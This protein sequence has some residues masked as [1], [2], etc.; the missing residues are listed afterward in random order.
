MVKDYKELDF[1]N[2]FLF[3]QFKIDRS[4]CPMNFCQ[5]AKTVVGLS[6]LIVF[7]F[8]SNAQNVELPPGVERVASIE[9]IT[10]YR[11]PNGLRVLLFPDPTKQTITVNVAYLVG[12]RHENYG[13]TGMAH[14]LE[15]LMFK[16]SPR[17]AHQDAEGN[18]HGARLNA[19][20]WFDRTIYEETFPATEDNLSWALD[21]E[22]DRMLNAAVTRKDL[23]SEFSVVR[24]EFEKGENEPTS[25]L[26]DKIFAT[27]Y[28]WHNYGNTTIGA[29][30]DIE[31]VSIERLQ[32][33]YKTYY[34]PDN[35]VLVIAGNLNE[36]KTLKLVDQW[37]SPLARP[38]RTLPTLYTTEPVQDGERQVTI[39][40]IGDTQLLMAGYHLPAATS[41]DYGAIQI[42][43]QILGATPS[44]RL[45]KALVEGKKAS[46]VGLDTLNLKEP[47]FGLFIAEVRRE[48]PLEPARDTLLKIIENTTSNP[49]TAEEVE[50]ARNILLKNIELNFNDPESM[51]GELSEWAGRG[52]WRMFFLYRD[53]IKKTTI[54][55][56]NRVAKQYLKSSNRTLA[57][58]IPTDKP[59]RSEIA[60]TSERDV[61]TMLKD[62]KGGAPV[63][64]GETFLPSPENIEARV[65]RSNS[66]GLKVA[67]L[68]KENRGDT[69]F[70]NL[71]LRFG[72]EKSLFNRSTAAMFVERM[73]LRGTL[74]KSRQK[75][76]DELDRLRARVYLSGGSSEIRLSIETVRQNLPAVLT[77][78]A[79]I[80][81]EPSFPVN[82][83][84][85]ARQ[86]VLA[87]I[88]SSKSDP[89][90]IASNT[91]ERHFAKYPKGDPR[92]YSTFDEQIAAAKAVTL[93][94]LRQFHKDFYGASN[95]EL[96]IVGDFD[97]KEI[98]ALADQLFGSWKSP[99][100]FTRISE[101]F[102]EIPAVNQNIETPDKESANFEARI[103]LKLGDNDPDFPAVA[104]GTFVFGSGYTSRLVLRIREKEG[105][106][107]DLGAWSSA[108]ALD[109]T[110]SVGAYA[111]F[112]PQNAAKFENS[113]KEELA[114]LLKDGITAGELADAKAGLIE[115]FKVNRSQDSQ[116]AGKLSNYL[117]YNRTM[118]WDA[119]FEK[120][121][122]ALTVEQVN[123]AL[124]KYVTPDKITLIKVGD[125]AGAKAK[126]P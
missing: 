80:L 79:E 58:F 82:E 54:A 71:T 47:G 12:S 89:A 116:L 51:A 13:E 87:E 119:D 21:F 53:R 125:F 117:F 57:A 85:Q 105:L 98:T 107:Y 56:V 30:S 126:D 23:D 72:D 63:A 93:V 43:W 64:S 109:Q 19:N 100:K 52:D 42:L 3:F 31:N 104:V 95:G 114:R 74:K 1:K 97:E 112:A 120:K 121:I 70:A 33:F 37:F 55:D 75:I 36:T 78:A 84:E 5:L 83:F 49:P 39:R 115:R 73:L 8:V 91:I 6:L 94:Q 124:R 106:S 68:A 28:Q 122:A 118:M 50:R 17:H 67:L 81:R 18:Q 96:A 20:T 27:A 88:E 101:S 2:F 4:L 22:A 44:G 15:H 62:Y 45:H 25:V 48:M 61:A 110:G 92:Y 16:G 90:S 111:S 35:A 29:R 66:G 123:A 9:G 10:E 65:K 103:S 76:Q 26:Y 113:F 40:R 32:A 102:R 24:N 38:A 11:F 77:L 34:Q 108:D 46:S 69:V 14:L 86:E 60:A 59:D 99:R 7:S 41:A